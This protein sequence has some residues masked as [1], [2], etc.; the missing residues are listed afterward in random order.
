MERHS[1]AGMSVR[2][3]KGRSPGG[4]RIEPGRLREF[5]FGLAVGLAVALVI[6]IADHRRA[7]GA[8]DAPEPKT[9]HHAVSPSASASDKTS[10]MATDASVAQSKAREAG[11]L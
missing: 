5:G 1:G 10:A 2:D 6:F 11:S 8:A 7:Q 3:Y 9:E 4:L